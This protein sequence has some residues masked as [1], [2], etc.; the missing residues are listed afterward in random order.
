MNNP[1]V[2]K[3]SFMKSFGRTM[4]SK[5]LQWLRN[6]SLA[7]LGISVFLL[8]W[9]SA[10]NSIETSLGQF[11]GPAQVWEQSKNIVADYQREKERESAFYQR[12]EE[13]NSQRL[14]E[15]PE[16]EIRLREYTG[17][18]TFPSQIMTSLLTVG[19]GF[20][21]AS[22]IAVP[23]GIVCGLSETIYCSINFQTR[24]TARMAA[25]GNHD[26]QRG[27]CQHRTCF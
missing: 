7:V 20:F 24:F 5:K 26:C 1:A 15:D 12:Q 13:R 25:F 9:Q 18:P 3:V 4:Y 21:I 6:F 14:A 8:V 10:A 16:A 17:Q 22:I 2:L 23:L 27:F 11:P 19:F